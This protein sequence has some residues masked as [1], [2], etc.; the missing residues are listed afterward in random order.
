M[1]LR[2]VEHKLFPGEEVAAGMPDVP[3]PQQLVESPA[4]R[5]RGSL[6]RDQAPEVCRVSTG[7][8]S[9]SHMGPEAAQDEK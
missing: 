2:R 7:Q 3:F 8:G 4:P 9:P 1:K 5:V 6:C